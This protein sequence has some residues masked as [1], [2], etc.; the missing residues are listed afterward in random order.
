M[1]PVVLVRRGGGGVGVKNR[2]QWKIKLYEFDRIHVLSLVA[3]I[4]IE[5]ANFRLLS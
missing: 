1:A 2:E 5:N 3:T 4:V